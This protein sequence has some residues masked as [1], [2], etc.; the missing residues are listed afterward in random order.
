MNL[1]DILQQMDPCPLCMDISYTDA[2]GVEHLMFDLCEIHR[3]IRPV[4]EVWLPL[5]TIFSRDS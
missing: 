2:E 5:R 1:E 3:E 4:P